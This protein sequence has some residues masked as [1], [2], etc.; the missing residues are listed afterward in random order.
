MEAEIAAQNAMLTMLAGQEQ[1][2]G[3]EKIN[4]RKIKKRCAP[5]AA[6]KLNGWALASFGADK[7]GLLQKSGS[8]ESRGSQESG[9]KANLQSLRA[10]ADKQI[11]RYKQI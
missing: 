5:K 4:D 3:Y 8:R 7:G 10:A 2:V 9:R 1:E 11:S 6:K